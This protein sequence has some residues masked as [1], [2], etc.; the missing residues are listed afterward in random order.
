V[1]IATVRRSLFC[2]QKTCQWG[3]ETCAQR[4]ITKRIAFTGTWSHN[5][6][7][8][9]SARFFQY[10]SLKLRARQPRNKRMEVEQELEL[11]LV[12][13]REEFCPLQK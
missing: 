13:D 6:V 9:I 10:L 12:Y 8:W 1:G 7:W 11:L 2:L 5:A 4:K 3:A